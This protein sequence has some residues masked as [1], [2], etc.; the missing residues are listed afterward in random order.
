M[1]NYNKILIIQTAF[2][3]DTILATALIETIH[4]NN[5][6]ASISICVRKGNESL[7]KDHPIVHDIIIWDKKNGKYKALWKTLKTIRKNK[8]DMVINLQRY[9][10]TGVLTAFSNAQLKVGFNKNPL[11]FLF[12]KSYPH[13]FGDGT[14]EIKR[15]VGLLEELGISNTEQPKLYPPSIDHIDL[16]EK[17]IT[18]SPSSVWFTKAYPKEKWIA[19]LEASKSIPVIALGGPGDKDYIQGILDA[20]KHPD[21]HNFC[22]KASLLESAAIMKKAEMNYV[23]DSAPLHL[24]SATNAPVAAIFCSTVKEFGFGPTR[25]NATIIET[26]ESL[27]CRP[28]GVHGKISCPKGHFKC[29]LS[30][31]TEQLLEALPHD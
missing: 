11:S 25:E 10:N 27:E 30:I 8:F 6:K 24:C 7:F 17:F 4:K 23:N 31:K 28:C 15:N 12:S 29:G 16:P 21:I 9:F 18:I 3:G 2:I 13:A 5:P 26:E 20:S 14:H 22:G 1:Q 19:F